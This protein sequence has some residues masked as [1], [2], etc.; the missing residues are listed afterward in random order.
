ME[1]K[2][3][4]SGR[5]R[6]G[7]A[8]GPRKQTCVVDFTW[9]RGGV[10]ICFYFNLYAFDSFQMVCSKLLLLVLSKEKHAN[11]Q[12]NQGKV[13]RL[14]S[15]QTLAV[16]YGRCRVSEGLKRELGWSVC[17]LGDKFDIG[18]NKSWRGYYFQKV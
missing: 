1:Q 17:N 13:T 12:K 14:R 6:H 2:E 7:T 3:S 10:R 4:V 18:E 16:H 15:C 11:A 9:L 8:W 5:N